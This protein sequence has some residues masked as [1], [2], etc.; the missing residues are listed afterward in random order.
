MNSFSSI[1]KM[2]RLPNLCI[3]R[4]I[5]IGPNNNTLSESNVVSTKMHEPNIHGRPVVRKYV[6]LSWTEITAS[7]FLSSAYLPVY[8]PPCSIKPSLLPLDQGF[9]PRGDSPLGNFPLWGNLGVSTAGEMR[10]FGKCCLFS[11]NL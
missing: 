2:N 10:A 6:C 8:Q 4:D 11:N 3:N 7:A 5:Y 1:L 9:P